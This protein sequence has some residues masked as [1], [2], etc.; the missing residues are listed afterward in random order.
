MSRRPPDIVQ[1]GLQSD[2]NL[3]IAWEVD[4]F[5][6]DSESPDD[7]LA[8]IG[9]QPRDLGGDA[10]SLDISAD[11]LKPL[12]GTTLTINIGFKW[13]GPPDDIRWSTLS[14][15]IPRSGTTAP[16]QGPPRPTVT[17]RA[18]AQVLAH[19]N[20]ITV[21]WGS[22]SYTDGNILWGDPAD[23]RANRHNIKPKRT[24]YHG[25]WTTETPLAP[26]TLYSFTVQVRNSFTTTSWV[27]A[28]VGIVS[29][30][31]HH[32]V[33]QFLAASGVSGRTMQQ[34]FGPSGSRIR[35]AMGI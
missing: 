6:S 20:R 34:A 25:E 14:L 22:D 33:R 5:F 3:R 35:K 8:E 12:T 7:V 29:A 27:E 1:A 17:L 10:R 24:V 31:N 15:L 13:T 9:G 23:P 28:T 21:G 26:Q 18:E 2:G 30:S 4:S 11:E 19:P 16:A 32:S